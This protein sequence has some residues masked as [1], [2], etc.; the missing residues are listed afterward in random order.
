MV[1]TEVRRVVW[2]TDVL[3]V[4]VLLHID[5]DAVAIVF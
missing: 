1:V 5:V 4:G 2:L 3:T